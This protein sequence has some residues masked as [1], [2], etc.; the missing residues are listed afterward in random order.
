MWESRGVYRVL[1]VNRWERD[2]FEGPGI[3]GR[4]IL[5]WIFRRWVGGYVLD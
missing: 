2:C 4:I 1:V 5:R 3:G